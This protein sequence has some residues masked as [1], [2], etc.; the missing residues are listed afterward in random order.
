VE[1]AGSGEDASPPELEAQLLYQSGT[2]ELEFLPEGPY[3]Y[4]ESHLS[5]VAIQHGASAVQGS[6]NLLD[7]ASG[8]NRSF[9]MPGRPGF[10]FPTTDA[11]T[12]LL[13]CEKRVG[14]YKL[15]TGE[16]SGPSVDV[17]TETGGTILNDAL[18]HG[19][20]VVFGTKDL[21]FETPRAGLYFWRPADGT[22]T[23]LAGEQTCS[24][25]KVILEEGGRASLLDI[26]TPTRKVLSYPLDLETGRVGAP[27]VALDLSSEPAFPDGMIATPDGRSVVIAFY[28]PRDVPFGQARQYRLDTG[29]VEM[30]W[31]TPG[32]PRVTCPQ[33]LRLRGEPRLVLTT[34]AE[35]MS[36]EQR[37]RHPRAGAL[38]IGEAGRPDV[39]PPGPYPLPAGI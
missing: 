23:R 17:E 20:A 14:F 29:A 28:D 10:A 33:W 11:G 27:R 24:N 13:G 8:R 18:F 35:H 25:G 7:L 21:G 37:N 30:V 31:R 5:W 4:G 9:E 3:P 1:P 39:E 32:S 34:A 26:D 38:F 2:P 15:D 12:F 36:P 19:D 22:L 6:I 16:W